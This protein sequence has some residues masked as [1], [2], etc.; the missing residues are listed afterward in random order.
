MNETLLT[1]LRAGF[2]SNPTRAAFS[3]I[4]VLVTIWIATESTRFARLL[5]KR[6]RPGWGGGCQ[7]CG[8]DLE[9][10]NATKCPECGTPIEREH[11][12]L[13]MSEHPQDQ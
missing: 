2:A 1:L 13:V 12:D 7:T 3:T 4:M 9:G 5:T 6:I 10:L 8:Y 11:R